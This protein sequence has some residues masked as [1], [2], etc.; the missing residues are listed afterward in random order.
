MTDKQWND[1]LAVLRGEEFKPSPIGF[2]IDCPWLPNW[3]GVEVADYLSSETIWFEANRKAIETFPEVWFLPGF[4]SEFGM[5]T[6][7]SAFG[8]RC[9]FPRNEF[10][11]PEKIIQDV[12]QIA[13]LKWPD[14]ATDGLLP[15]ML[16]R[17]RWAQPRTEALGH[18]IRFSVSRGPLNVATF[19]MGTTEFLLALKTDPEAAHG[20]LR[21][22]TDFLTR[23]HALQRDTFPT[24]DGLLVLDDIV[25]LMSER[26]F[27]A[28]GFPYLKQLFA[29]EVSVKFF[30]ND[31][32]CAKSVKHYP[33]IGINL[34]NPGIQNSLNE[35]REL[36]GS[37]LTL[38]GNIPPRDVLALGRPADVR[39]AVKK[40]LN[41][42]KD[43]ARLILSC[44]GGMPPGVS[45]ENIR[46]FIDAVRTF[47][48]VT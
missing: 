4:W 33:D 28:F 24:I 11:F 12:A 42:T 9:V 36:A 3:Y 48:S 32:P 23:W 41:E 13:E 8:T 25:G 14:P 7:P 39:N 20:L 35:L 18:K 5:C 43:Y 22:V 21:G 29:A 17:L 46:A 37:K 2:I 38:L 26:D 44:G 16:N 19:L 6:E 30:H 31:A 40:L 10:P 1:L 15:F 34:F 47:P 45:T 27:L